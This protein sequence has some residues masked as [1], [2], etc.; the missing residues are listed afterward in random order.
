MWPYLLA[1]LALLPFVIQ[2]DPSPG[3]A[4]TRTEARNL[5]CERLSAETAAAEHPGRV[6]TSP[7]RGDYVER[8]ALVC[9]GRMMRAGL[10]AAR[11]EAVLDGLAAESGAFAGAV[12]GLGPLATAR[13]WLV[14]VHYPNAQ[15]APKLSFAAQNALRSEG[16]AVSDRVPALAVGDVEVITRLPP[17]EAYAAA[18]QRYAANGSLRSGQDALLAVILRDSRATILSAGV[19]VDGG[20]TWLR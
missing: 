2:E 17:S 18:C 13:T 12:R 10:R 4:N 6:W 15:V 20:W 5:E 3:R 14:E 1:T 8:S 16:L 19:C 11:D 9:E 7:P